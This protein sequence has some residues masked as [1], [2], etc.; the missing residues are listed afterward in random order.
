MNNIKK[1]FF[2]MFLVVCLTACGSITDAETIE[3]TSQAEA[4]EEIEIPEGFTEELYSLG[5]EA[6]CYMF[7]Y[8]NGD[9]EADE[10]YIR[11]K[12]IYEKANEINKDPNQPRQVQLNATG[13]AAFCFSFNNKLLLGETDTEEIWEGMKEFLKR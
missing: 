3:N 8:N 5:L 12:T 6:Y 4:S 7:M 9:L 10:C 2:I 11:L 1:T 13:V